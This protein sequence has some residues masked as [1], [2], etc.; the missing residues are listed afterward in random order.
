M[1]SGKQKNWK[2]EMESVGRNVSHIPQACADIRS[3]IQLKREA[4]FR[5]LMH[6]CFSGWA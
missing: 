6:C 1:E 4:I 3:G 2:K 5:S